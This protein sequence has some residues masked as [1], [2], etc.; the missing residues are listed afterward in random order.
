MID[1]QTRSNAQGNCSVKSLAGNVAD[2]SLSSLSSAGGFRGRGSGEGGSGLGGWG[3]GGGWG[4][5]GQGTFHPPCHILHCHMVHHPK[6]TSH[7]QYHWV[8]YHNSAKEQLKLFC[9]MTIQKFQAFHPVDN[10][11]CRPFE[12]SSMVIMH[13]LE[14]TQV[15]CTD[16]S[17][18][19]TYTVQL[20]L[21][22]NHNNAPVI[23]HTDNVFTFQT[24]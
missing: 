18:T 21:K 4:G 23:M 19:T 13:L 14:H 8:S 15:K 1:S 22:H 6:G 2:S 3:G 20:Y 7:N 17:I 24:P 16:L 11:C 12:P 5:R 10:P 9:S